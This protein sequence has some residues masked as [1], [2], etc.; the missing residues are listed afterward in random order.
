MAG[1]YFYVLFK[2]TAPDGSSFFGI[3]RTENPAYGQDGQPLS[4]IGN[5]PK[6][7][8]K[9][10]QFGIERLVTDI[11]YVSGDYADVSRRL[12]N[13][14]TPATL[15]DPRCLNM[16]RAETNAKISEALTGKS[17]SEE[18]K[19]AIGESMLNNQNRLGAVT[20][21]ET[22]QAISE[23]H[24]SN[25]P[26]W[27]HKKDTGEEIQLEADE[28]ALTGFELGRLPKEFKKNFKA[29]NPVPMSDADRARMMKD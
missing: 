6:L 20:S 28:E 10:R 17:K 21:E 11:L 5:G 24:A 4:Y 25:K 23:A 14:L 26:K 3:H 15:A 13:I 19:A 2:T 1:I 27:Y 18:H 9:A 8:A 16:P 12:D 29:K 7:Q 22:K